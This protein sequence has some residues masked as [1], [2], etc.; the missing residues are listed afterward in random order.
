MG[1]FSEGGQKN[2]YQKM[3]EL[4]KNK[5]AMW[6]LFGRSGLAGNAGKLW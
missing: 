5:R 2:A 3:Q 4:I 1:D 6:H